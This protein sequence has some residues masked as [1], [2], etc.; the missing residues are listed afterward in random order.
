MWISLHWDDQQ[1]RLYYSLFISYYIIEAL[2]SNLKLFI[3]ISKTSQLKN[4]APPVF[5]NFNK[6][7]DMNLFPKKLLHLFSCL[8]AYFF[9][10][11]TF[12]SDDDSFLTVAFYHN[13]SFN[14]N[15]VIIFFKLLCFNLY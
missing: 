7:L 10:R 15:N 6:Q 5:I 1:L 4:V 2:T 12:M 3:V 14:A 11:C 9:E 8:N 13:Y